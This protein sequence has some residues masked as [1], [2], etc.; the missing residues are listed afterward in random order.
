MRV[1]LVGLDRHAARHVP[2][3]GRLDDDRDLCVPAAAIVPIGAVALH[4]PCDEE[5]D[6]SVDRAGI[7]SATTTFVAST[8][9]RL[10]HRA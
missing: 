4:D 1:W 9:E 7:W 2:E 6:T 3:P 8:D 10:F 5:A